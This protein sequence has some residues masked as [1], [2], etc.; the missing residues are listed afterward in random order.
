MQTGAFLF[1][2]AW[3][4]GGMMLVG[5]GLYKLGVFSAALPPVPIRG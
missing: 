1:N 4:A 5:M 2:V 3:R